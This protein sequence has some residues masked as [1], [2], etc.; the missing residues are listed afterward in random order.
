MAERI[1]RSHD[2]LKPLERVGLKLAAVVAVG[3]TALT[4]AGCGSEKADAGHSPDR[5]AA[6]ASATPGSNESSPAPSETTSSSPETTQSMEM[7]E[8]KLANSKV[9]T[10]LDHLDQASVEKDSQLA[11]TD[12]EQLPV[13]RRAMVA[14]VLSDA[15][16]DEYIKGVKDL[17]IPGNNGPLGDV[18]IPALGGHV[19]AAQQQ[20]DWA[21]KATP[22]DVT[23]SDNA[24][25]YYEV[26]L[27]RAIAAAMASTGDQKLLDD[28]EKIVAGT[29]YNSGDQANDS[30][31][32]DLANRLDAL[33]KM[34]ETKTNTLEYL[35]FPTAGTDRHNFANEMD[36]PFAGYPGTVSLGFVVYDPETKVADKEAANSDGAAAAVYKLTKYTDKNGHPRAI[37]TELQTT[38]DPSGQGVGVLEPNATK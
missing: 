20:Y 7:G 18:N 28:A 31:F 16:A 17:V 21:T 30:N 32:G 22:I 13:D 11:L 33:R 27:E 37:W 34:N 6:T 19:N 23:P 35:G 25:P 14:R 26:Q 15:H 1:N 9:Y 4:L 2:N 36:G 8:T 38:P 24:Q 29:I 3:A 10:E 5:P 12:F